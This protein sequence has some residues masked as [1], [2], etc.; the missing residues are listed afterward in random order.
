MIRAT[1]ILAASAL[2]LAGID[3]AAARPKRGGQNQG[4]S[5]RSQKQ[6]KQASQCS[7]QRSQRGD[8]QRRYSQ[9][10]RRSNDNASQR[11]RRQRGRSYGKDVRTSQQVSQSRCGQGRRFDRS[12]TGRDGG[13][14][15]DSQ[16]GGYDS[17]NSER[18]RGPKGNNGL[19]NGLDPQPP[20]NPPV[21]DGPGTSPGN[22]GNRGG[23]TRG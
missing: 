7:T 4:R 8:S 11:T 5:F 19:G 22:P 6:G 17:D 2:M 3:D 1:L 13:Y 9:V 15:K 21:N 14:D 16:R 18:N 10:R 12:R 20:G 23:Q